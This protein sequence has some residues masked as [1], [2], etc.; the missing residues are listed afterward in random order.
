MQ[1]SLLFSDIVWASRWWDVFPHLLLPELIK[2]MCFPSLLSQ[3]LPSISPGPPFAFLMKMLQSPG[4]ATISPQ[5]PTN[6][7]ILPVQFH[8]LS[9]EL[10]LDKWAVVTKYWTI[11]KFSGRCRCLHASHEVLSAGWTRGRDNPYGTVLL[12]LLASQVLAHIPHI[13][14]FTLPKTSNSL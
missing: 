8:I 10:W 5:V 9:G 6:T 4:Q 7:S 11:G 12:G 2:L 14:I 13:G 3:R 1:C